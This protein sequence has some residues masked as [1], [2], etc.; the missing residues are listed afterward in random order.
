M[1][2]YVNDG[3][4]VLLDAV[5]F[6]GKKIGNI[7][8]DGIDWGGDA[9]EYLKIFA[10]QVRNAPVKKLKKKDATNMLKLRLIELIPQNC[11]DV[12]GGTVTGTKWEAPAESV[13]L[14]G[15]LKILC[16]TGQTI[17][18]KSMTLD[19]NI[20]GKIGG[21]EPL[22]VDCELEMMSPADGSSP[23]SIDDTTP[24]ISATPT[25]LSFTKAG[26]SKML[27][28]EA[29]GPFSVSAAPAGFTVAIVNGRVTVTTS[30]NTGAAK[31]GNLTFTL[32]SDSTKTAQVTLT[33][34]AGNV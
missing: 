28:I 23:F 27:D 3:Y 15:P 29:S 24:F 1:S 6:N 18:I 32:A 12:M 20:R 9:A 31:N 5:Y 14:A 13:M 34:A 10:A 16:G 7:S 26:E 25:A 11:Y 4:I 17:E 19:G 21:D 30:V 22:G 8:E 33:Q 2:V